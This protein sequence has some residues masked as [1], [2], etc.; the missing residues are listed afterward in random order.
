[1]HKRE[2]LRAPQNHWH[3]ACPFKSL[4]G[5]MPRA[6]QRDKEIVWKVAMSTCQSIISLPAY[7]AQIIWDGHVPGN[8]AG[9][10]W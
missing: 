10:T 1:M 9:D 2:A 7:Q 3:L 4:R 6:G 5:F 8:G